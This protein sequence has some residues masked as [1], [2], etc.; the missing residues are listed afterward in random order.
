MTDGNALMLA[1]ANGAAVSV[2]AL[3]A[4]AG[5]RAERRFLEFFAA[6]IRNPHTRRAYYRAA[7]EFLA[8]CASIGMP[9]I[10]AIQPV[11][12]ATW[13]EA[14]TRRLAAPSVKQR[15]AALRHL[16]DWLVNGQVVPI[17]PAHTVRGPRHVVT[18]GQTPVLDP[19]EARALLDSI[20][21]GNHAGLRDR[22]LIALMVYSFAR[23]GAAL[24]MT[25][26]DVYTQNRRLWVRLREKGGKRHAMPCHH[27]LEEYLVAYLEGAGLRSDPKGPLF[28]TI[29]RGT[30]KLTRTVLPQ[31]NAYAMIRRRAAAA[32][33][34]TKLGNHSF[35]ATGITAYLKNGGTLEKAAAMANHA[36]T[37]TTQLYDRRRE[38][39]SLNEVERIV[40]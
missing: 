15:L 6:N 5:E 31:A 37:R 17:N 34:A 23:I 35:R 19:A 11:H 9:S 29:G 22:A 39:V 25:V 26:E 1:T 36:S 3:I 24:G 2:P 14:S 10:A 33:I 7:D 40:I 8:W 4:A 28:C 21:T 27:N 16:F 38:E 18:I 20:D 30:R 32:G 12:V 13:I